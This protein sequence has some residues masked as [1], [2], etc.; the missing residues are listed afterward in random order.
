MKVQDE[1]TVLR[2]VTRELHETIQEAKQLRNELIALINSLSPSVQRRIDEAVNAG[3]NKYAAD[4]ARM[5]EK[6]EDVITGRFE[7][8]AQMLLNEDA[9]A[10][11]KHEP[12]IRE[13]LMDRPPL[14]SVERIRL[15][16]WLKAEQEED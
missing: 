4:V 3:L 14:S 11:R 15:E 16:A 6:S 12:S 10:R 5:I 2:T 1:I 7:A 13:I 9:R 8:L